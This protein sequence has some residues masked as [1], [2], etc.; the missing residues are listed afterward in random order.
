MVQRS[1]DILKKQQNIL[2]ELW[3]EFDV[4]CKKHNIPYMLYAGSALG[5]VRHQGII[6]WDDDLDVVMMRADYERFL[7]VAYN[8]LD[9]EKFFLQKEFSNH[10][11]MFFSKIRKNQTAF[12]ERIIAKDPLMHQGIYM[13]IFACDNLSNNSL[14]RKLQFISARI[15][16]A[17]SLYLRGYLTNSILKKVFMICSSILPMA[18]F[19]KLI[20]MKGKDATKYVHTF[21]AAGKSYHKNIYPRCWLEESIYMDFHGKK[22]PV[23]KYYDAMLTTVYGD[24]MT[25]LPE[26]ER[27]CK[28]H[29]EIVDVENSYEQYLE[30]QRNM[31]Y[32]E[33][34]R[35]IR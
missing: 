16:V 1:E 24:Y 15:V 22:A 11:P 17:K 32:E 8:E 12:M 25:P 4:I 19:L 23:S 2:L 33:F 34:S 27:G 28:I 6:P 10:W 7:E 21:L 35:S 20:Q 26:S 30:L 9:S 13:D 29:A 14:I 18:P 5:A 3:T 31:K